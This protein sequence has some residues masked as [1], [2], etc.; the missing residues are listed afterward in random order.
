M[1]RKI[2][3]NIEDIERAWRYLEGL[4]RVSK[5]IGSSI[6]C[7]DI[8][9]QTLDTILDVTG[10]EGAGFR[11][12]NE[13][14]AC[15][16]LVAHY[17]MTPKMVAELKCLPASNRL[18]QQVAKTRRPVVIHNMDQDPR[19]SSKEA[20]RLGYQCLVSVPL[21]GGDQFTGTLELAS[22]RS[23]EWSDE[24]LRWLAAIG[25]LVGVAVRH[26]Q[27]T[28]QVHQFAI[29][30]E[31]GRISQ[32]IHDGISQLI[33][34]IRIRAET[35]ELAM[36]EGD[37]IAVKETL[38]DIKRVADDAFASLRDD[39]M[40]LREGSQRDKAFIT[41]LA[42]VL[43]RFQRQWGILTCMELI[44]DKEDW[45]LAPQVELQLHRV[46]QEALANVRR[47]AIASKILVQLR[48]QEDDLF[49]EI[50]D[51]G[52]GFDL[53][54]VQVG[55]MGLRIMRERVESIGGEFS[56]DSTSSIGTGLVIRIPSQIAIE[57]PRGKVNVYSSF[58][59]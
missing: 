13:E 3:G 46:V 52:Q 2:S 34:A 23:Y 47:H 28:E 17:G 33:S 38:E 45:S 27:L 20:I 32:E 30:Q 58:S 39:I 22:K 37:E 6:S 10:M 1:R 16:C 24:E 9:Q 50:R 48:K 43:D 53:N 25:R 12:L 41:L 35:A 31:R 18:H 29:R 21:I 36:E 44:G 5:T 49:L 42:E 11:L 51:D 7:E 57:Y 14:D 26:V 15:F 19:N 8:F 40:G 56:I 54:Q 4:Q 55:K 59:R